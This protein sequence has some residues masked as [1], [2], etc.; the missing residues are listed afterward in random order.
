MAGIVN[1]D[2]ENWE[3]EVLESPLPVLIDC[4]AAWCGPCRLMEPE[5]DALAEEEGDRLK[6]AKL[7]T[8]H[9]PILT[10]DYCDL[11]ILP[12]CLLFKGGALVARLSGYKE[13]GEILWEIEPHL[14]RRQEAY[15][16]PTT[17]LS[18]EY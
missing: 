16:P 15:T 17:S 5:I 13:R 8:D 2:D 9:Y 4:W 3:T 6:V 1:L 12:T 14:E 7:D 10:Q 11:D 18:S